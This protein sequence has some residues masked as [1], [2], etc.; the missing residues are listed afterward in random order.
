MSQ[1]FLNFA[2]DKVRARILLMENILDSFM[3]KKHTNGLSAQKKI[4]SKHWNFI[5][6]ELVLTSTG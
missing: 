4:F 6:T 2:L 5:E 1:I 3:K